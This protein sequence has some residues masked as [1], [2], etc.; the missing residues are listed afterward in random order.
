MKQKPLIGPHGID[1][2][3]PGGIE[4]LFAFNR[5]I[6]GDAVMEAGAGD[7]AGA[8]SGDG[9]GA[10]AGNG[11]GD[12]AGAGAGNGAG[13]GAGDGGDDE[14]LGEGGKKALLAE[15]ETNKTLKANIATM[16]EELQKL[17]DAGKTTE[18]RESERVAQLEQSTSEQAVTIAQKDSIILRYQVAAA[19]GLDL[20]AA[21]RLRGGSKEELEADADAWIKKWGSSRGVREVPGAGAGDG[22]GKPSESAPGLGRMRDAYADASK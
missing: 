13:D 10:G 2:R 20:E 22:G 14:Q 21:E 19:K 17:R 7:G 18:Q 5:A 11:A 4:Q 1:L 16:S 12:G 3:A 8:G 9:A 6:F 15:R